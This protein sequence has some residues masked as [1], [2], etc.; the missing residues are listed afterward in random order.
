MTNSWPEGRRHAIDQ[1]EHLAWNARH[2]PGTRQLCFR[3][4][5]ETGRCEEDSIDRDGGPVCEECYSAEIKDMREGATH[6]D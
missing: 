2:W 3:C 4:G 1:S 6:E 5:N